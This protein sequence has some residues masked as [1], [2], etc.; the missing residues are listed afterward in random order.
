[1]LLCLSQNTHESIELCIKFYLIWISFLVL[2]LISSIS[3]RLIQFHLT[4]MLQK[5]VLLQA[6]ID[7]M[8]IE[9]NRSLLA[10]IE[11]NCSGWLYSANLWGELTLYLLSIKLPLYSLYLSTSFCCHSMVWNKI[12]MFSSISDLSYLRR[13]QFDIW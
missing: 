2:H 1:M 5:L 8:D 7:S 3:K 13:T 9:G 4:M 12:Q 6:L 10:F 11:T